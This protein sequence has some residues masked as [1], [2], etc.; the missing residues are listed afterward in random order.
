MMT[1]RLA[2]LAALCLMLSACDNTK[3]INGLTYDVFGI[4]NLPEKQNPDIEYKV[5]IGSLIAAFVFWET[6]IVPVYVVCF[7]LWEPVGVKS[8][9]PGVI[10]G[11]S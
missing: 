8:A 6:I 1:R 9:T 2:R 10:S 7:D 3:T 4:W 5:S 11:A